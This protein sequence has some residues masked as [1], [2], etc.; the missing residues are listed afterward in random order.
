MLHKSDMHKYQFHT[1]DF[2][3]EKKRAMLLLSM[4][5]G[6]TVSTLTAI[7]DLIDS[8]CVNKVLVVAPLRVANSVWKQEAAL[9]SHLKGLRFQIVTGSQQARLKAL[10]F[11]ADVYVINRENIEWI[12]THYGKNFP[13]DMIV[14][15]ESSSF[16]NAGSK[17]FKAIK[18]TLP[19][20]NY[21]L[22]LTGT[23]SPNGLLDL[24]PQ[25]YLVDYGASLGK[26][27]TVF[28]HRFFET[29]FMGYKFT[30][31]EGAQEQIEK[32]MS[33]YTLSMQAEDYLELPERIYLY[34]TVSL[35]KS[36][37]NDYREFEKNL[38]TEIEGHE[39]EALSA[40]VLANKLL[41]YANGSQYTDEFHNYV[42]T[43]DEKLDALADL[44]DLNENDNILVAY[45]Y[46]SDLERLQ[47]RFGTG[48]LLDAKQSVINDWNAGK[49]KLLFAHPQS[50]G[51]GIN[52]QHGG[53]LIVWFS[54][55]WNLEYYQQF[56]ARLHR[57]GQAMPVRIVHLVAENTIDE[58]VVN[59]LKDKDI[60]QSSLLKALR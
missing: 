8:F 9:W 5:M 10:Q 22:L 31:R 59:V 16:K 57:Q 39:I 17:R 32:L 3:K 46:K 12:V 26:T 2:I 40:G 1:V 49:I 7:S 29:D 28:K 21:M 27:M 37:L 54:L 24:W 25:C 6:K 56:N 50:A 48:I 55:T 18:K 34:E 4:G 13:F 43:H 23:P 58:R 47:K 51:H 60:S 44:I 19:F 38:F 35:S 14:I 42:V 41:Q 20:V 15:D 52:I 45:N 30:P 36:V 33:N 11:D 53:S